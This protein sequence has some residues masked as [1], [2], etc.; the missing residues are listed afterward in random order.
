MQIFRLYIPVLFDIVIFYALLG[1]QVFCQEYFLVVQCLDVNF[2]YNVTMSRE[3]IEFYRAS[4][5]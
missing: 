3:M 1:F 5:K 2:R 4:Y